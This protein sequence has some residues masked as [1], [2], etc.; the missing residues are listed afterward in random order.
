MMGS[1][2]FCP[3]TD[4][5][6]LPGYVTIQRSNTCPDFLSQKQDK[7]SSTDRG[8]LVVGIRPL[9]CNNYED[10]VF[11]LSDY[12]GGGGKGLQRRVQK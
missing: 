1:F 11:H 12:W 4:G 10:V 3:A 8:Q 6:P 9:D 2:H 7:N 5:H